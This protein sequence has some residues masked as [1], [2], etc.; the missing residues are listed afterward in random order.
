MEKRWV[1]KSYDE[2]IAQNLQEQ[3]KISPII[4]RLLAQRGVST[5]DEAKAFFRPDMT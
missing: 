2:K 4:C 1:F 3:L 5:Y